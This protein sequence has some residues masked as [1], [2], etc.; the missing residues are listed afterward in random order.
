[1]YVE[2]DDYETARNL[3][4]FY[5]IVSFRL[6]LLEETMYSYEALGNVYKFLYQYHKAIKCYKKMIEMAWILSNRAAELRGYDHISHPSTPQM[7]VDKEKA[8]YYH[9]RMIY[10]L[11][12]KE[13]KLKEG[14]IENFKNKHYHLF[15][16][17]RVLIKNNPTNEE[18]TEQ[19]IRHVMLYENSKAEI[20]L[21][22][23]DLLRNQDMMNNSFISDV[24]M[25]FQI[26]HEK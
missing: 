2:F 14:I 26:I 8:K 20:D 4:S 11:Y 10:G 9:E 19:F 5:K 13:S 25:T 15:N 17:D 21:E 7:L 6:E 24:D 12:E 1:M 23:Y 18:L 22:T 3:Y 16:D